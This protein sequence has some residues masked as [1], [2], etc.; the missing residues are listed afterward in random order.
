MSSCFVLHLSWSFQRAV[1]KV[2]SVF[3]KYSLRSAVH[4]QHFLSLAGSLDVIETDGH[5]SATDVDRDSKV[6]IILP[7]GERDLSQVS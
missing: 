6:I 2:G 3:P 1:T 4:Y 7:R 5:R